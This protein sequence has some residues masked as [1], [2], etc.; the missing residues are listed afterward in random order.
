M[1]ERRLAQ[2]Y[3]MFLPIEVSASQDSRREAL[4][5]RL[6]DIS[7][8]GI[9]FR[10]DSEIAPGT[11]LVFSISLPAE[12]SDDLRVLVRGVGRVLRVDEL[13]DLPERIFGIAAAF[14][15]LDIVSPLQ[16]AA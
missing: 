2:R 11:E 7:S 4:T 15:R 14:D 8:H 16:S 13:A 10:S 9:Y 12:L 1:S 3:E 6:R 5:A